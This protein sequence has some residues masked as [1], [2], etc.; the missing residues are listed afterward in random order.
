MKKL[1]EKDIK[2]LSNLY[3]KLIEDDED[4]EEA[5]YGDEMDPDLTDEDF[6][7]DGGYYTKY[8]RTFQSNPTLKGSVN[9]ALNGT[10]KE[11]EDE[12]EAEVDAGYFSDQ[13]PNIDTDNAYYDTKDFEHDNRKL[14]TGRGHARAGAWA[15]AGDKAK[16]NL[17][18]TQI[19]ADGP[20]PRYH[21][22]ITGK[23]SADSDQYRIEPSFAE[24]MV[25]AELSP[26]T[27]YAS[28]DDYSVDPDDKSI[29]WYDS[30]RKSSWQRARSLNE[31]GPAYPEVLDFLIKVRDDLEAAAGEDVSDIL[32]DLSS[33]IKKLKTADIDEA[34]NCAYELES[35][36]HDLSDRGY[37]KF[38][39]KVKQAASYIAD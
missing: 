6:E 35:I 27:G 21:R 39:R 15:G 22:P 11:S 14:K 24:P 32:D 16:S 34:D 3:K 33:S 19:D 23:G 25:G 17:L 4:I 10:D 38:A 12:L 1:S 36:A 18:N 37:K 30:K 9:K 8:G 20:K 5:D 31:N 28:Y 2:L 7:D 26:D 13:D 29:H